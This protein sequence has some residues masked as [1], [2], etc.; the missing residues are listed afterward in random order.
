[1][2]SS[3]N[4]FITKKKIVGQVHGKAVETVPTS[5]IR[6]P[7]I[8]SQL[9]SWFQLPNCHMPWP[10]M[11]QV[12]MVWEHEPLTPGFLDSQIQLLQ[13][14]GKWT[15]RWA[16]LSFP[17]SSHLVSSHLI[18][19]HFIPSNPNSSHTHPPLSLSAFRITLEKGKECALVCCPS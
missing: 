16:I 1:M 6:V 3:S 2:L 15:I 5:H 9:H 4:Y 19:S 13:E 18:S 14:S 7:G 11:Q 12:A 10:Q 8:K 17:L